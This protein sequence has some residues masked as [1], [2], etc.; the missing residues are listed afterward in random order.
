MFSICASVLAAA[1]CLFSTTAHAAHPESLAAREVP[2]SAS[3]DEFPKNW[4]WRSGRA[5]SAH[6]R[7]TGQTQPDLDVVRW[8]GD[9]RTIEAIVGISG[10]GDP[11]KNLRGKVVVVDFWATWCGPC[12]RAI[13]ENVAMVKEFADDGLVFIGIHDAARGSEKMSAVAAANKINYALAVDN[14]GKSARAWNVSFWPTYAVIDRRGIVRAIGLQPQHVR[15]VVEKLLAE[16]AP[17]AEPTRE[18]DAASEKSKSQANPKTP[19]ESATPSSE[20]PS[21]KAR[22]ATKT[23]ASQQAVKPVDARF[24]EGNP[25]R[26]A[27]LTKFDSCPDAPS[28]DA[29][30]VWTDSTGSLAA[31]TKRADLDLASF[32]LS[33]LRGQIVVLDFWATWCGPCIASI[34]KLNDLARRYADRGVVVIGVCHPEGGAKMQEVA[35]KHGISYPICLDARGEIIANYVVDTY[36]D[37]YIIDREGRL[38]GADVSSAGLT[39]AIDALL[40]EG[41]L[42][43]KPATEATTKS[44]VGA[45]PNAL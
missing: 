35:K 39:D 5:A 1:T 43:T 9:A 10:D 3:A 12:M 25:K 18:T 36:P 33:D 7:M 6:P 21:E 27:A 45:K 38:R 13:P 34:P 8:E 22:D 32:K 37:Y 42:Q 30:S 28:L 17:N 2:A 44:N 16:P 31:A 19:A 11:W 14:G 4:F 20:K 41:D 23:A 40:A 26:R 29:A 24:L 15:T